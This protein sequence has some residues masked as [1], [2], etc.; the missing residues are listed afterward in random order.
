M[1]KKYVILT[2]VLIFSIAIVVV[3]YNTLDN[4]KT[5]QESYPFYY[6]TAI[7][8]I[9]ALNGHTGEESITDK[10]NDTA[11]L[12]E[13]IA[14]IPFVEVDEEAVQVDGFTYI[15]SLEGESNM[16]FSAVDRVT[17]DGK[18]YV[19]ENEEDYEMLL[20]FIVEL[21]K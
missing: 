17:I 16:S 5:D 20:D 8:R 3:L 21:V 6:D 7:T 10:T 4:K 18:S 15:I 11:A 13:M 19:F 14:K 1:K 9:T 12:S 2:L